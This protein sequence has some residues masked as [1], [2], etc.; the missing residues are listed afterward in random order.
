MASP[1]LERSVRLLNAPEVNF[2]FT[3]CS[4]LSVVLPGY[5]KNSPWLL[6][7]VLWLFL[8]IESVPDEHICI[9]SARRNE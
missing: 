9:T 4:Q 5:V 1:Y 3:C 7:Q 6:K 8:N 2:R